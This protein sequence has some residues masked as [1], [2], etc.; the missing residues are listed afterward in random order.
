MYPSNQQAHF[1]SSPSNTI[2]HYDSLGIRPNIKLWWWSNWGILWSASR[3]HGQGGQ[4]RHP[5]LQGDWKA[6]VGTDTLKDWNNY[7]GSSCNPKSNG[8]GLHLL[9]F[10]SYND[11]VLANTLGAHK[12]SQRWTWHAPIIGTHYQID[13]IMV[14][15]RFWSG[16]S[17]AKTRTFPGT[18]VGSDH[19]LVLLNFRVNLK[20]ILKPKKAR[21]K[22]NLDS[23][24][25]KP[26]THELFI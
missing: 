4:G 19:D 7:C 23:V 21:I 10:T 2:Q 22:F 16:I 12:V 3:C 14:Q 13:Y 11:M 1:Y 8:Q 26:P 5:N 15:N 18:D 6:K 24:S 9:E 20:K 17:T 25:Y